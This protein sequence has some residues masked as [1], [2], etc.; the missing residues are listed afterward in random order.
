MSPIGALQARDQLW[1]EGIVCAQ[2]GVGV[3]KYPVF[4]RNSE[5][6]VVAG[7]EI[8]KIGVLEFKPTEMGRILQ[9]SVTPV[10]CSES[11]L[12]PVILDVGSH[13]ELFDG[14]PEW[15]QSDL[16][17]FNKCLPNVC[18]VQS[19]GLPQ[20]A[21]NGALPPIGSTLNHLSKPCLLSLSLCLLPLLIFF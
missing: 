3:I 16:G 1:A 2:E 20:C 18:Y 7:G 15:G 4:L 14:D 21:L 6:Y 9:L 13:R 5:C 10:N 8:V 12:T 17:L 19:P 11:L